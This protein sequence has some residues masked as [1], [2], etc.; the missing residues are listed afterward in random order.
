M[1]KVGTICIV[2]VKVGPISPTD[3]YLLWRF[4]FNIL[5][6]NPQRKYRHFF[7]QESLGCNIGSEIKK[8]IFR[9]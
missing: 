4:S 8:S 3:I 5:S 7:Q 6:D 1:L 9:F 2:P